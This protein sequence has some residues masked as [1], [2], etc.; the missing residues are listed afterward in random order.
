MYYSAY[1]ADYLDMI[2]RQVR[3]ETATGQQNWCIFDNTALGEAMHDAF[4]LLARI[5][6]CRP[7]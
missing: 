3:A 2:A 6:Q 7:H 4:G 1:T 5:V